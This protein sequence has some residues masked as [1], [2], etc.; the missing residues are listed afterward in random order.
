[1][2]RVGEFGGILGEW[3]LDDFF[4]GL[5]FL[6]SRCCHCFSS[7]SRILSFLDIYDI[8]IF[9]SPTLLVLIIVFPLALA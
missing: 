1:M 3:R 4:W 2:G 6:V 5:L 8:W 9:F 7:W